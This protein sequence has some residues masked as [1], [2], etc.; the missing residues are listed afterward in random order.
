VLFGGQ[1]GGTDSTIYNDTWAWDGNDW[2]QLFPSGEP[3]PARYNFAM[4]F[5]PVAR[6]VVLFGGNRGTPATCNDTW[7]L[8]SPDGV[9]HAWSN[10]LGAAPSDDFAPIARNNVAMVWD[11]VHNVSVL[12]GGSV[13]NAETWAFDGTAGAWTFQGIRVSPTGRNQ[14]V[15]WWDPVLNRIMIAGGQGGGQLNDIWFWDGV[16]ANWQAVTPNLRFGAS[17]AYDSTLKKVFLTF[18]CNALGSTRYTDFWS[19]N[20]ERR[21]RPLPRCD[22]HVVGS[23]RDGYGR[24]GQHQLPL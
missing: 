21:V 16:S 9:E 12:F 4:S 6:A 23:H 7:M 20:G 5:D 14:H 1:T 22:R 13:N 17:M 2:K 10:P 11:P 18:G 15:M 24:N 3:P 8:T 19:W